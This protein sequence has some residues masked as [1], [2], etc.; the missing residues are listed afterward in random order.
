M[1]KTIL[2]LSEC[3]F[4]VLLL[5]T[6]GKYNKPYADFKL[7]TFN[8]QN[9]TI[10]TY[11]FHWYNMKNIMLLKKQQDIK[12][13]TSTAIINPSLSHRWQKF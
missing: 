6:S 9:R 8:H 10:C 12:K 2:K 3:L 11:L 7:N 1:L 13:S 4:T 5:D